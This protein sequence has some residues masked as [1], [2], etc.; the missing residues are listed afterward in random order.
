MVSRCLTMG[1]YVPRV[2][3]ILDHAI[4]GRVVSWLRH[5]APV[6]AIPTSLQVSDI[7]SLVEANDPNREERAV[8]GK[9]G[10][11]GNPER[12]SSANSAQQR[13]SRLKKAKLSIWP[14]EV[15]RRAPV[16]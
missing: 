7:V 13:F 9:R 2:Q 10:L 14:V 5:D 16:D 4:H 12:G 3:D 15:R 11:A 1:T 8:T 6:H